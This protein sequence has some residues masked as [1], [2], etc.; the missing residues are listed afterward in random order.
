MILE[1]DEST[2]FEGVKKAYRELIKFYHPDKFQQI[3]SSLKRAETKT[4][5]I[6]EAYEQLKKNMN[7]I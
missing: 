2:S 3:P 6:K 7:Y 4:R 5:E 1:I